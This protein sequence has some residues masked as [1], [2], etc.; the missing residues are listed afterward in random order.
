MAKS[1]K[2]YTEEFKQ[3]IVEL[4]NAGGTSYPKLEREYG[5]SKATISGWV[6]QLS[7]VEISGKEKITLKEFKVLRKENQRLKIE[8]EILKKAHN[9]CYAKTTSSPISFGI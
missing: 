9:F 3:Q 5:V 7:K 1:Q 6:K 8:N 4:Y 2:K